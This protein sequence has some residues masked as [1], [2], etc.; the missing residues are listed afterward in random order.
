MADLIGLGHAHSIINEA[1][2]RSFAPRKKL[3]VSEWADKERRLSKKG[4][5]EPGPWRTDRNP[6]LR[7]P[8]DCLSARSAIREVVLMFPV[9]F[10]KA[11]A[12]DTPI[13][14]P[15]GWSTMGNLQVGDIVYGAD[16]H[17][18]RITFVSEVFTDHDCY[19]LT[20]SDGEKIVADAGHRWCVV[21]TLSRANARQL[22][23]R[24]ENFTGIEKKRKAIST[25]SQDH[26]IIKT[27]ESL[28][29]SFRYHGKQS[30]F[31]IRVSQPIINPDQNLPIEPYLL[32]VW[33]GDGA[34]Q[35]CGLTLFEDDAAFIVG[36]IE[37]C[38][39]ACKVTPDKNQRSVSV[40]VEGLHRLLTENN[41]KGFK[42]IPE[43]YLRS[44]IR[45]RLALLQGLLDTDG[46][47]SSKGMV[48]ICSSYPEL[49]EGIIDLIRSLGFKPKVKTRK[50][51]AK[52]S[53]RITFAAYCHSSVFSLPRKMQVLPEPGPKFEDIICH[54]F[55]VDIQPV[56]SVPT[57]CIAV[58]NESHLFLCGKGFIPTHN[59]EVAANVLGYT[60]DHNPGPIMVCLP[61][62][63]SMQ[64]WINQKLNTMIDETPAVKETL[65][66]V[67]SRESANTRTF[68]D[69]LGGQL[70]IEHAGSP[71]RLKSTSVRTLIVDELDEF[72]ANFTG[73]DDPVDML[74]GRT[75]AFPA[76]YKRLFISTP[77]MKGFSRTEQFYEKSDQRRFY[78]A[79]PHCGF[80]Q[81]LEWA[82]L[83]WGAE[84]RD[85]RYACKDCGTLGTEVEWKKQIVSGRWVAENPESDFRGYHINGL[86]YQ[87]G[88]GPRWASL[89]EDWLEAQN[90]PA[91]L[92]TFINDRLAEPWE[93][94][95]MRAVKLNVIADRA[96][97]YRIRTVPNGVGAITAGVDTQD[98]RLAVHIV[99][100]GKGMAAWSLD[101]IE[102]IGDPA[103]DAV[104]I[105]LTDLLNRPFESESGALM[106]ILATAID[107]GGHR[108]EA[109]KNFVRSRKIRRPMAIFGAVP[110]NAPV[111][112]RPKAQDV[113]WRGKT[114]RRGVHIYHVGTVAVKHVF[115][116]RL[117]TDGDKELSNRMLH[118]SE[119]FDAAFFAGLTSE[120]FDPR[121]NRFINRRGARNEP[122][123]TWVYAYAAAHH[124]ELRLQHYTI[125]KWEDLQSQHHVRSDRSPPDIQ[126]KTK[127]KRALPPLK[128]SLHGKN[129]RI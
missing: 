110:N 9:Q 63:V 25:A 60:M 22:Q 79:C 87:I 104:W 76:T 23:K 105:A 30:R 112:S 102:L 106:P 100:W 64:K 97:N 124:P 44:S 29:D 117:S 6:P 75:S 127:T 111:L 81:H 13:P 91:R 71:A 59:T 54:R 27:S 19:E 70:Y 34:A 38:G 58:D 94:P 116:G 85:P 8:M 46:Y 42:H 86:Y 40:R 26:T 62:D 7:E 84:G 123:D 125:K 119:Q 14:T 103:D 88:L 126:E 74:L 96:E 77:Q 35:N 122:L 48:E 92:K 66:S 95:V 39:H 98:N 83:Q 18:T 72:A 69:Y 16:G 113:S 57:R 36:R 17:P 115:Y 12:I 78:I 118:F 90:D 5:A 45:Q 41:L 4:S 114:D 109:V 82:G 61:A 101:Y 20:F 1:R 10:G 53:T 108:T 2:G 43:I 31:A 52:D 55:I 21:D 128:K 50:T 121:K 15:D 93:D 89:V 32:G 51:S 67:K 80:E 56:S 120:T 24:R 3:T 99:G 37:F 49:A 11:L 107:A 73:G 47:S 129:H 65:T 33:L 68:K 28:H